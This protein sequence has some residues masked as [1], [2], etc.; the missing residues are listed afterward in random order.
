MDDIERKFAERMEAMFMEAMMGGP[1]KK[2]PQRAIRLRYGRIESVE[3]D[4]AGN[5]IE[6]APR[7]CYGGALHEPNCVFWTTAN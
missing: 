5:V 6:P 4:G 2:Q 7:C 1:Q 3:L